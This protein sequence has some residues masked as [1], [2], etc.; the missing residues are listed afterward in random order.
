MN[1]GGILSDEMGLGKTAQVLGFLSLR[2]LDK[3]KIKDPCLIIVPTSLLHNWIH[4]KSR[5]FP[6]LTMKGLGSG[7]E[8]REALKSRSDDG[9]CVYVTTYGLMFEH[10]DLFLERAWDVVVFDEVH[11]L[12][13]ISAQRTGVARQLQAKFKL[14]VSGTPVENNLLEFYSLFDLVL[15][16]GLGSLPDFRKRYVQENTL[17]KVEN[18]QHLRFR[19][20]PVLLRRTKKSVNL[21]LP[22]KINS[23]VPLTMDHNQ[24]KIYRSVAVQYN[25]EILSMVDKTGE[26]SAQLHMLAALMRLRQICSHPGVIASADYKGTPPKFDYL[27]TML[28]DIVA[29][30]QSILIFT[31]FR[32][33]LDLALPLL[34]KIAPT[35]SLHGSMSS[36]ERQRSLTEFS[37]SSDASILIMTLK[38]GGVG[39]NLTKA[40]YVFHLEPWWNPAAEEQ[41][42]DRAHRLGQ[43]STVNVYRLIMQD[44]LEERMQE[45]KMQKM[46][47]FAA[48]MSENEEDAAAFVSSAG[49]TA[50]DFKQLIGE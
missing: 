35:Y 26:A 21:E 7:K 28:P 25:D 14:G 34:K 12:K 46:K 3:E 24:R 39:L 5:F 41:A 20:K 1:L 30:G 38:T 27:F 6:K 44:S 42:T 37:E 19:S 45:M 29:S 17:F 32:K 47:L 15:P 48:L 49:L 33:T 10:K 43:K 36:S 40:S 2:Q 13:N 22:E 50:S 9:Q 11:Q 23:V 16:G 8:V 18:M 4:E 31:Q